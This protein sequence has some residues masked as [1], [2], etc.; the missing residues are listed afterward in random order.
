MAKL[1]DELPYRMPAERT[2]DVSEYMSVFL[3]IFQ[4]VLL[5][6]ISIAHHTLTHGLLMPLIFLC[7]SSWPHRLTTNP[8]QFFSDHCPTTHLH[9]G[10]M[11]QHSTAGALVLC[12]S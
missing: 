7:N 6:H 3:Q 4:E 11:A 5:S 1:S 12:R 10:Q 2:E 8:F 9:C